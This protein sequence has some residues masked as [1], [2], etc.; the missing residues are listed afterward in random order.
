MKKRL[1]WMLATVMCCSLFSVAA[2]AF[3]DL[4]EGGGAKTHTCTWTAP[5]P[6]TATVTCSGTGTMCSKV[7]DCSK[8]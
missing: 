3:P 2:F 6:S 5:T 7:T 4:D 1:R 8:N